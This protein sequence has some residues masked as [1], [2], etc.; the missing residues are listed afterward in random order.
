MVGATRLYLPNRIPK[1]RT[2]FAIRSKMAKLA[3]DTFPSMLRCPKPFFSAS[4][5]PEYS[6]IWFCMIPIVFGQFSCTND[7]RMLQNP[8]NASSLAPIGLG[9]LSGDLLYFKQLCLGSKFQTYPFQMALKMFPILLDT[10]RILE[11]NSQEFRSKIP[12]TMIF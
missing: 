3:W 10:Y 6:K 11:K 2:V 8:G 1:Q 5:K 4:R 12:I 9:V 7:L